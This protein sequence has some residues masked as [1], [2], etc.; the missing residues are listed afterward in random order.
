MP[1][2]YQ[3][4]SNPLR[5]GRAVFLRPEG[6]PS[7]LVTHYDR[8]YPS[9][10]D[11]VSGTPFGLN[12]SGRFLQMDGPN[13]EEAMTVSPADCASGTNANAV[14]TLP[15]AGPQRNHVLDG[16]VFGYNA[17]PVSG[18]LQ[19]K[20]DADVVFHV[21]VTSAG[22]GPVEFDP[23][24]KGRDDKAMVITLGAGGAGVTGYVNVSG[25]RVE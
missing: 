20:D 2:I 22:V 11:N 12:L 18:Y 25:R 1:D 23:P 16:L 14:I 6:N 10:V 7:G 17:T 8:T 15:A 21:P 19:I 13:F 24:K 5:N 4:N 3:I 9:S